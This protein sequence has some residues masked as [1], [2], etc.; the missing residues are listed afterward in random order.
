[1]RRTLGAAMTRQ[2]AGNARAGARGNCLR[3]NASAR[4]NDGESFANG[5]PTATA[6]ATAATNDND[7]GRG[8]SWRVIGDAPVAAGKPLHGGKISH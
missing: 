1:M 3:G 7:E 8:P 5:V 6:T 2:C 4:V